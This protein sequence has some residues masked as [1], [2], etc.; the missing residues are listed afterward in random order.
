MLPGYLDEQET[1]E[2]PAELDRALRD[3]YGARFDDRDNWWGHSLPMMSR[4]RTPASL[5]LVEEDR[6]LEAAR[7][8]LDT[9]VLATY[10]EG[11]LLFGEAGFHPDC[12][13]GTPGVKV[14]ASL[15]P[16]TAASGACGSCPAP[17]I[18]TSALPSTP[19]SPATGPWTPSSCGDRSPHRPTLLCRRDRLAVASP[20]LRELATG[21]EGENLQVARQALKLGQHGCHLGLSPRPDGYS[22]NAAEQAVPIGERGRRWTSLV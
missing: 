3:G 7:R 17:T 22:R 8:L 5:A 1:A 13:T 6:F 2:L 20:T 4:Q 19:G 21:L 12:G 10:A 9:R 11:N 14:V 18:P 15:E 16:L